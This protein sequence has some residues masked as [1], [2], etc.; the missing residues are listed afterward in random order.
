MNLAGQRWGDLPED[1]R[2]RLLSDVE[3]EADTW[4]F[5]LRQ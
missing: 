5:I 1:I 4:R 3:I 2:M